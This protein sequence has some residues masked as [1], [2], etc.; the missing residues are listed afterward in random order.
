[1]A[2]ELIPVSDEQA[3]AVQEVAKVVGQGI[4]VASRFFSFFAGALGT[5]ARDLVGWLFGDRLHHARIRNLHKLW[6][7]TEEILQARGVREAQKVSEDIAEP[8]LEAARK[9]DRPELQE[10]WARLLA[11]AI[12]P[13]RAY[14]VRQL[15]I[16][17]VK[18]FDPL[19]ARLFKRL[20][21]I[22]SAQ[23]TNWRQTIG[24][25]LHA[26]PDEIEISADNLERLGYIQKL[27][28][29]QP[30]FTALGRELTRTL[31]G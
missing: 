5:E 23:G 14:M 16:N 1:M 11:A 2:G 20:N 29:R 19:D 18:E 21:T 25:E 30:A 13:A 10:L 3:K 8:I 27:P 15:F 7:R 28:S 31:S 6:T 4:D 26:T 24:D 9:Q 12:D 17:A 22:G